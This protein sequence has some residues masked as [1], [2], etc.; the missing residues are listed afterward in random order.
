MRSLDLH[1]NRLSGPVPAS[2]ASLSSLRRLRLSANDLSGPLPSQLADLRALEYLD[3]SANP[4]LG[5]LP[6]A[7]ATLA[8]ASAAQR[9]GSSSEWGPTLVVLGALAWNIPILMWF[10]FSGS[11][12]IAVR[13]WNA[14]QPLSQASSPMADHVS[15]GATHGPASDSPVSADAQL[16]RRRA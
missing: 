6:P 5:P 14:Q 16:L 4:R 12:A 13:W 11:I 1:W 9:A 8:V 3:V 7:L 10:C 15:A 2:L